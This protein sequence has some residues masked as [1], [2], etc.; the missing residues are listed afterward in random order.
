MLK[1]YISALD[2]VDRNSLGFTSIQ[3]YARIEIE[4]AF[5]GRAYDVMLHVYADTSRTIA[6]QKIEDSYIWIGEQEIYY[7][8]NE[9]T[10]STGKSKEQIAVTY[11]TV[12]ISGVPLNAIDISYIGDDPRL[13]MNFDLTIDDIEFVLEEWRD[14]LPTPTPWR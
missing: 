4:Y 1:P 11:E 8:P 12:R 3:E 13:K 2:S 5:D 9:Y 10:T 7:G 14:I 6:Y